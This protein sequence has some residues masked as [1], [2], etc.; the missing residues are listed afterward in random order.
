MF[1]FVSLCCVSFRF[2][3][4]R[5]VAFRF[6]SFRFLS[7][8][9]VSFRFVSF[10]FGSVNRI[11]LCRKMARYQYGDQVQISFPNGDESQWGHVYTHDG[12]GIYTVCLR[13]RSLVRNVV[14]TRIYRIEPLP[15]GDRVRVDW[16]DTYQ[17]W[18]H[19]HSREGDGHYTFKSRH[20]RRLTRHVPHDYIYSTCSYRYRVRAIEDS[21]HLRYFNAPPPTHRSSG[22]WRHPSGIPPFPPPPPPP[23]PFSLTRS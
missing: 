15:V 3:S 14:A 8:R 5:F 7:F 23:L 21:M 1:C 13:D 22:S 6:V 11:F 18:G 4:L 19:I 12:D 20:G 10:R 16:P 9:F 2:V 17:E